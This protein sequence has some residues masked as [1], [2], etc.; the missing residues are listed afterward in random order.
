MGEKLS[1][2]RDF[3][4]YVFIL[5]WPGHKGGWWSRVQLAVLPYAG[6]WAYRDA[7]THPNQEP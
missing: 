4:A 7:P 3:L 6:R 1:D 5:H 2:L